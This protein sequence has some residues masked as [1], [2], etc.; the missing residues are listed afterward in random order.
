MH[1]MTIAQSARTFLDWILDHENKFELPLPRPQAGDRL[2]S[3]DLEI[4]ILAIE[5]CPYVV[6]PAKW[7]DYSA[8][9][10]WAYAY[11]AATGRVEWVPVAFLVKC[12][13]EGE[14]A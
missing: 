2:V 14:A 6:P 13:L 5:A 9:S 1:I 8:D 7:D 3:G 12:L 11:E 4:E 10:D